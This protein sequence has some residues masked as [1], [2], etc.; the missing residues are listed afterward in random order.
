MHRLSASFVLCYHG[1]RKDV[2]ESLIGGADFKPSDN[3]YDW[4]GP[5]V[6]F[7]EAN[8]RRGVRFVEE[9]SQRDDFPAYDGGTVVGA[10]VDLGLCLDFT[11]AASID[12]VKSAYEIFAAATRLAGHALPRNTDDAMRRNL[13][14]AVIRYLH[15]ILG[16]AG[17][18]PI[19][20]VKG[21]FTEGEPIYPG[22]GILDKTHIQIAVRDPSCIKGVFRVRRR[23]L[24]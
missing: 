4:L 8:P 6:Y 21:V 17:A 12:L 19:Q 1:C 16:I 3:D 24:N 5:G 14:C 22:A 23:D 10:I 13:D 15:Q 20:S 11:T 7:W 9:K 18:P 2:A